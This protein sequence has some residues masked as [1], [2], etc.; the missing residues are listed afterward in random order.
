MFFL[1]LLF[2]LNLQ[3][4]PKRSRENGF[5]RKWCVST[6]WLIWRTPLHKIACPVGHEIYTFGRPFLD[7]D[8]YYHIL[9][10]PLA[11]MKIFKEIYINFTPF[12]KPK[13]IYP[14]DEGFLKFIISCLL[15]ML[16]YKFGKDW[17]IIIR[18]WGE[19]ISG[20]HTAHNGR[21]TTT[22]VNP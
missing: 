11:E 5:L 2:F 10:L 4:M 17:P 9:S 13:I 7:H 14:W 20:R 18:S 6:I 22:E 21:C 12:L 15:Q 8:H 19:D 1:S 3:C 16:H